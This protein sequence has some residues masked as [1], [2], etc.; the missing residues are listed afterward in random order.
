MRPSRPIA[1]LRPFVQAVWSR[2]AS[3]H[4]A[5]HREHV[6]PSG[7][8]HLSVRLDAPLRLYR[9]ASD[10]H[11]RCAGTATLAGARDGFYAKHVDGAASVGAVLRPGAMQALF[12][13]D[14]DA[15][16]GQ[17]VA[18]EDLWNPLD[19]ERLRDRLACADGAEHRAIVLQQALLAQ[20]RP[21]RAMHPAI[22]RAMQTLRQGRLVR[23]TVADSGLSHRHFLLRFRAATG[24]SPKEYARVLRFRRALALMPERALADVA[25]AAGYSDQAHLGREFRAL[26]GLTPQT[27]RAGNPAGGRHVEVNFLQDRSGTA[28]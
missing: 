2:E 21:I 8:M 28:R 20:V 27:Y 4:V 24:L 14:A 6:L 26:S 12:G 22:A 10:A 15:L 1:A 13:C 11:G 18:L 5:P 16:Q 17:H 9:D 3:L 23:E 25:F 7:T 19:V